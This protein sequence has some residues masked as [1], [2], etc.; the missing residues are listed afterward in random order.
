MTATALAAIPVRWSEDP[1]A[2][3]R[4][5]RTA[6]IRQR[7]FPTSE[8][9]AFM[10]AALEALERLHSDAASPD[11]V[12]CLIDIARYYYLNEQAERA[13]QSS[14]AA[15][16]VAC[17]SGRR[18]LEARARMAHG[19]A[20]RDSNALFESLNELSHAIEL[21]RAEGDA[22]WE[23]KAL[24]NLGNWYIHVGLYAEAQDIFERI[25]GDFLTVG[26]RVSAWMALDNAAVSA[27]KVGDI[28]R[29]IAL[30]DKA[31]ETWTGEA[32]TTQELLWVVQGMQTYCEL[33]LE[34]G[35]LDEAAGCARTAR[36]V[37]MRSRSARAEAI[38]EMTCAIADFAD[39]RA[40]SET[41]DQAV[42]R[43]RQGSPNELGAALETA[44]RAYERAEQ[45]DRALRLQR[46]LLALSAEQKF[47]SMRR[48]LGRPSPDEAQGLA[49][50]AQLGTAVDRK[51]SD[52]INTAITQALRSAHDE[53]RIFR[54]SRLVEL[55]TRSE[56]WPPEQ[57]GSIA[58]AAKLIDIGVMV[59]PD[60]LL[61]K[62][63][64]LSD[65]ERTVVTEHA[66]FGADVLASARLSLLEPCIPVVRFHHERWDGSGASRLRG[67][68][69]PLEARIV[70]LCD[71][72]DALTHERPWRPAFSLPGALRVI[73]A[74]VGA[75]FDP[76]LSRRFAAWVKSEFWT[77]DDFET[78]LA[79]EAS[80]NAYV[81][82]RERV[83][84]LVPTG[85]QPTGHVQQRKR[86]RFETHE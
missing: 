42:E 15:V 37:A 5:L 59:V 69:I 47:E 70:S 19:T 23:A 16:A 81:R 18:D 62:P 11:R 30:A 44:I 85:R 41:I 25:A 55:F 54:V 7:D 51:V 76:D 14:A 74:D 21:F 63:R 48:A 84:R 40:G 49:K 60:E 77:V 45:L 52:L 24:N 80:E 28:H 86:A 75:R 66:K 73:D 58:L 34:A 31:T 35:R 57:S 3:L 67:E 4:S 12:L 6:V 68:Q 65:D 36:V 17:S 22:V 38:A 50:M 61:R 56:G 32:Q 82:M 13:V 8:A 72:F 83:R 2:E 27:L 10:A 20:L 1:T 46:E 39:S 43:A 78:H 64:S 53:S 29:G 9:G 26:D 33:L 79:A 71:A